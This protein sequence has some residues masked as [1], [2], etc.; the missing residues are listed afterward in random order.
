[1]NNWNERVMQGFTEACR[2]GLLI[3]DN[4]CSLTVGIWSCGDSKR[5]AETTDIY[6][7]D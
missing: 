4:G 6:H 7:I 5:K 1:M 2:E 3:K